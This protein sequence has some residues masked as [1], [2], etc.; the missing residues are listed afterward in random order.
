MMMDLNGVLTALSAGGNMAM[1]AM[2]FIMW[3][4]DRRILRLEVWQKH[5]NKE[6]LY[7]GEE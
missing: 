6:P 1:I 4:M 7:Y 2:V 3:R 5:H